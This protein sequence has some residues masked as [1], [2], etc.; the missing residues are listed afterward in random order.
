[1]CD[2]KRFGGFFR[3]MLAR[4][5]L[6]PPSQFEAMFVSAVHDDEDIARTVTACRESLH[7]A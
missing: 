7:N 5:V 3:E 4:G 2:T 1:M 6:L